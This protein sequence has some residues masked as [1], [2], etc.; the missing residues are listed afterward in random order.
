MANAFVPMPSG[1][2]AGETAQ[3]RE[4]HHENT[5]AWGHTQTEIDSA[6]Q[7]GGAQCAKPKRICV[8]KHTWVS[9]IYFTGQAAL[10]FEQQSASGQATALQE[11]LVHGQQ[12]QRQQHV[13]NNSRWQKWQRWQYC[14]AATGCGQKLILTECV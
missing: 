10:C 1:G 5:Q 9:M 12:R 3:E 11:A 2:S 4:R 7:G 6:S 13:T 14:A 8:I